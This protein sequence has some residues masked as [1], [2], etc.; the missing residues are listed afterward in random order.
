MSRDI[1]ICKFGR[2]YARVDDIGDDERP[3]ALGSPSMVRDAI[4]RVFAGTDWADHAWGRFDAPFGSIAFVLNDTDPVEHFMLSARAD[5][6]VIAAIVELCMQ[7]GW[8]AFDRSFGPFIDQC[9]VPEAAQQ[10]WADFKRQ[11]A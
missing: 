3:R 4:S 10:A 6:V 2:T 9:P 8:Q 1:S 11:R 5:D 7:Q